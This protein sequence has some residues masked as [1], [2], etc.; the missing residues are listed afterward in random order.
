MNTALILIPALLLYIGGLYWLFN[1]LNLRSI[2]RGDEIQ[3]IQN[4]EKPMVNFVKS[5]L[6]FFMI[7]LIIIAT[8]IVPIA[9]VMGISQGTSNT[10]GADISI[11]A[12]FQI[13]LNAINGIDAT[14]LRNPE[15]HGKTE[16]AID[17]SNVT[18]FYLFMGSQAALTF[19]GLYGVSQLRSLVISLKKGNAFS[20]DNAS[21]LKRIGLLVM[22]WNLVSPI[23]QYFAWGSVINDISFSNQGLDL[24]P[25]FEFNVMAIFIGALMMIL[26]DLFLEATLISQEQRLTI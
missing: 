25:A 16:I 2:W 23:F 14:G 19:A 15:M 10:W 20:A 9:V 4:I 22:V 24:F 13:D 12:G 8:L 18:A 26:S 5:A 3:L 1:Y 7:L 6:D 11:F 17:T 21:R